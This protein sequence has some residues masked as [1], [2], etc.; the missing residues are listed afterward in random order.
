[1][2]EVLSVTASVRE[3]DSVAQR[4]HLGL[5]SKASRHVV[6][7]DASRLQQGVRNVL[8]NT[9]KLPPARERSRSRAAKPTTTSLLVAADN[10]IGISAKALALIFGAIAPGRIVALERVER[11]GAGPRDCQTD[12][13]SHGGR[14][15]TLNLPLA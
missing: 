14:T 5:A 15:F 6:P 11:P 13:Q 4:Q 8:E 1:M 10:G 9:S 12:C 3:T 7:G 2:R